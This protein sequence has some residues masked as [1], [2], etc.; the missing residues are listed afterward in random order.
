MQ[1]ETLEN[2]NSDTSIPAKASCVPL[3][4]FLSPLSPGGNLN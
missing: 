4:P 2:T 3:S 1:N